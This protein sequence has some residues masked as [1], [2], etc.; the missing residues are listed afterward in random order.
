MAKTQKQIADKLGIDKQKVYRY[1]KKNHI[2]EAYQKNGTLY[3]DEAAETAI[4]KGLSKTPIQKEVLQ[5]ASKSDSLEAV[6]SILKNELDMKNE[7]IRELNARLA[8]TTAA[9]KLAQENANAA[10]ALHAGTMKQ[11]LEAPASV[12]ADI[13]ADVQKPKKSFWN[14]FRR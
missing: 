1:I 3:Y 7:Q 10:Q 5:G 13:S 14:R 12:E 6:I 8:E 4:I 9:L 2:K 11:Q